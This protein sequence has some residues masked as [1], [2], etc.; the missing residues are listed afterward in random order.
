MGCW[1]VACRSCPAQRCFNSHVLLLSC[2]AGQCS[3]QPALLCASTADLW[4]PGQHSCALPASCSCFALGSLAG[5]V[6]VQPVAWHRMWLLHAMVHA[7]ILVLYGSTVQTRRHQ[8][9]N[10]S[11]LSP[12]VR[13]LCCVV[14]VVS[15]ASCQSL[16]ASKQAS[17][18]LLPLVVVALAA[19][20]RLLWDVCLRFLNPTN[21]TCQRQ[22]ICISDQRSFE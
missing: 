7:M 18:Q 1:Q 5:Q 21:N 10:N 20:C 14:S 3:V 19:T 15:C 12:V 22:M 4:L 2:L 11:H 13:S 9:S 17:K 16:Q 6:A 8:G